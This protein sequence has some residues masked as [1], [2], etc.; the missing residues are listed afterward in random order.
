[1]CESENLEEVLAQ[2]EEVLRN[3]YGYSSLRSADR[4]GD[5]AKADALLKATKGYVK[6]VSQHPENVTL[7]DSTGFAPEGVGRALVGLNNLDQ[8]LS[9]DDWTPDSLFRSTRSSSLSDLIGV[10]MRVNELRPSLEDIGGEGADNRR[11]ANITVDWVNGVSLRKIAEDYFSD[12]KTD[13]TAAVSKACKAIYRHLCNS[14]P[15]GISALSKMPTSGLDFDNLPEDVSRQINSLPAMIYHGVNSESAVL[16]R[17][18]SVPRSVADPLGK[19]FAIDSIDTD[20]RSVRSARE[21][22]KSLNS[23]D[24]DAVRPKKSTMSGE[25]YRDIWRHLSGEQG[26]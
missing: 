16:M 15:W 14:G 1:M 25:D 18:N 22:L 6:Q 4:K 26:E 11:I 3:T 5:K 17:M 7:A 13:V 21:F 9:V 24:W 2:A 20:S 10:M 19:R 23:S 12:D 8:Q